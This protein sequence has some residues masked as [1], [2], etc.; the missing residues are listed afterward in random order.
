[1]S[2]LSVA[3]SDYKM[4]FSCSDEVRGLSN[5]TQQQQGA[6]DEALQKRLHRR[7]GSAQV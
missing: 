3:L 1:M 2:G 6:E 4:R 7:I 5:V